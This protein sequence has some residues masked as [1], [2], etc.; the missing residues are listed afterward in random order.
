MLTS[1]ND[2]REEPYWKNLESRM[3]LALEQ[4][5]LEDI[6]IEIRMH[7][8]V[9]PSLKDKEQAEKYRE[10][11]KLLDFIDRNE[12]AAEIFKDDGLPE[13]EELTEAEKYR[14]DVLDDIKNDYFMQKFPDEMIPDLDKGMDEKDSTGVLHG[15]TVMEA[16]ARREKAYEAYIQSLL[17][18]V[19]P[20]SFVTQRDDLVDEFVDTINHGPQVWSGAVLSEEKTLFHDKIKGIDSVWL[21]EELIIR[22]KIRSIPSYQK[23]ESWYADYS[24]RIS[25]GELIDA[26]G[27]SG[28][29]I[30]AMSEVEPLTGIE[31]V[32]TP[33]FEKAST[34]GSGSSASPYSPVMPAVFSANFKSLSFSATVCP[35]VFES[36]SAEFSGLSSSGTALETFSANFVS[37]SSLEL[38]LEDLSVELSGLSFSETALEVFLAKFIRRSSFVA[39]W[40]AEESEDTL[41]IWS[42]TGRYQVSVS[43]S[44][45]NDSFSPSNYAFA[46]SAM[47]CSAQLY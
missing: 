26:T 14:Q 2:K 38:A 27:T 18:Q 24:R 31:R 41:C 21:M 39:A 8:E 22:E 15:E 13:D 32:R 46:I 11:K 23:H 42:E 12:N 6:M 43:L 45:L 20:D 28:N 7:D 37:L 5:D 30:T 25:A 16:Q 29:G 10:Y 47:V 3:T 33:F 40:T 34:R 9:L 35:S 44:P 36:F 17:H 4:S 1:K 19:N